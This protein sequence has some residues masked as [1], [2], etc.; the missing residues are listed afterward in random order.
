MRALGD[1]LNL[2]LMQYDMERTEMTV[3]SNMMFVLYSIFYYQ[4]PQHNN[5]FCTAIIKGINLKGRLFLLNG[6]AAYGEQRITIKHLFLM[7]NIPYITFIIFLL[8]NF[9]SS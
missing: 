9:D 2:E 7:T 6:C 5:Y 8:Q 4:A 1:S 3:Y